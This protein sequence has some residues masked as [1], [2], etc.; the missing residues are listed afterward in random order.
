MKYQ[1]QECNRTFPI[2]AKA[3][4]LIP[5][6][7]CPPKADNVTFEEA[8]LESYVCPYCL[9]YAIQEY[10]DVKSDITALIEVPHSEVNS[11]IAEGYAVMEDK[12]YAKS[13]IMCKRELKGDFVDD[14]VEVAKRSAE[15]GNQTL[16]EIEP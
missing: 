11:K 8:T 1:C 9:S 15:L 4:A 13:T 6:L 5:K 3:E 7:T 10:V 2:P 16:K 14:A 12:I